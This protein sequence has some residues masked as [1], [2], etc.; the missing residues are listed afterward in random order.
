MTQK[1]KLAAIARTTFS[2][3]VAEAQFDF[4]IRVAEGY[5]ALAKK[6]YPETEKI[7]IEILGLLGQNFASKGLQQQEL[8]DAFLKEVKVKDSPFRN[9]AFEMF[10]N[11][12]LTLDKSALNPTREGERL[13]EFFKGEFEYSNKILRELRENKPYVTEKLELIKKLEKQAGQDKRDILQEVEKIKVDTEKK[14][15]QMVDAQVKQAE[16][17]MDIYNKISS[18]KTKADLKKIIESE[19]TQ[20]DLKSIIKDKENAIQFLKDRPWDTHDSA[21][22]QKIADCETLEKLLNQKVLQEMS[23]KDIKQYVQEKMET[24]KL[25]EEIKLEE[26]LS[27]LERKNQQDLDELYRELTRDW[28]PLSKVDS[29]VALKVLQNSVI[30]G[31]KKL[32]EDIEREIYK[33]KS[34]LPSWLPLP[35]IRFLSRVDMVKEM[36]SKVEEKMNLV[37][38]GETYKKLQDTLTQEKEVLISKIKN[39]H[40]ETKKLLKEV[41]GAKDLTQGKYAPIVDLIKSNK[42]LGDMKEIV[43][44]ANYEREKLVASGKSSV[45]MA[46]QSV[47]YKNTKSYI[48]DFANNLKEELSKPGMESAKNL[49]K[50]ENEACVESAKLLAENEKENIELTEQFNKAVQEDLAF[51]VARSRYNA[52]KELLNKKVIDPVVK[53]KDPL[54]QAPADIHTMGF[55]SSIIQSLESVD[56]LIYKKAAVDLLPTLVEQEREEV[57]IKS[58]FLRWLMSPEIH[59]Y[60][61]DTMKDELTYISRNIEQFPDYVPPHKTKTP[62]KPKEPEGF[63]AGVKSSFSKLTAS[64]R[65]DL[66]IMGE[67]KDAIYSA[68]ENMNK[69]SKLTDKYVK[70]HI[71]QAREDISNIT[72]SVMKSTRGNLRKIINEN[73]DQ[74]K[75]ETIKDKLHIDSEVNAWLKNLDDLEV[76]LVQIDEYQKQYQTITNRYKGKEDTAEYRIQIDKLH[77]KKNELH[78]DARDQLIKMS[79]T[80]PKINNPHLISLMTLVH[81]T[82]L[83]VSDLQDGI[84][85]LDGAYR[86]LSVRLVD[87]HV[88]AFDAL[89]GGPPA[90]PE[91][92]TKQEIAKGVLNTALEKFDAQKLQETLL[93]K[94]L[95]QQLG[96]MDQFSEQLDASIIE[97]KKPKNYLTAESAINDIIIKL[98]AS[99]ATQP[100]VISFVTKDNQVLKGVEAAREI[101]STMQKQNPSLK[102]LSEVAVLLKRADIEGVGEKEILQKKLKDFKESAIKARND[103]VDAFNSSASLAVQNQSAS[104][105]LAQTNKALMI[106]KQ[107]KQA[108][109]SLSPIEAEYLKGNIN[110]DFK[111]AKEAFNI[112]I[113]KRVALDTLNNSNKIK[114]ILLKTKELNDERDILKALF[115]E[116]EPTKEELDKFKSGIDFNPEDKPKSTSTL[117]AATASI[118]PKVKPI[119][120][121]TVLRQFEPNHEALEPG[122]NLVTAQDN[123]KSILDKIKASTEGTSP[124]LSYKDDQGKIY[125]KKVAAKK[126]LEGLQANKVTISLSELTN[127]LQCFKKA[128]VSLSDVDGKKVLG[129]TLSDFKGQLDKT[130]KDFVSE[131]NKH[132]QLVKLSTLSD[133]EFKERGELINIIQHKFD[134]YHELEH[135]FTEALKINLKGKS[136]LQEKGDAKQL[137]AIQGILGVGINSQRELFEKAKAEFIQEKM[138]RGPD[139]VEIGKK[140]EEM[141]K[142]AE[143]TYD[144]RAKPSKP[145]K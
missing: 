107:F 23:D 112:N 46:Q 91:K 4:A 65:E 110:K 134:A 101:M 128:D 55:V 116:F 24:F 124:S 111:L 115:L 106:Y 80:A 29:P 28:I 39:K 145:T 63:V 57:D 1:G 26:E 92:D 86:I 141:A 73:P 132:L 84:N 15:K 118:N 139:L 71:R 89:Q 131:C 123:V 67:I 54:Q 44:E 64:L 3:A 50:T 38:S 8:V 143:G 11:V 13:K 127:I 79:A 108:F 133:Q 51:N 30:P 140:A 82:M 12:A 138:V 117:D 74:F 77:K 109:L 75:K 56:S 18:C 43:R 119:V 87:K 113:E 126:I 10:T 37:K 105:K 81:R 16:I 104:E 95:D 40:F 135:D 61:S 97:S 130:Q 48:L 76:T 42:N 27:A 21:I 45:L 31:E 53:K 120:H 17:M 33:E 129:T 102:H 103:F 83:G 34:W 2:K 5:H 7:A 35:V 78:R 41:V 90:A 114:P 20:Q 137:K 142:S 49:L 47:E 25:P 122:K 98:K 62:E 72:F 60:V 58:K 6:G 136:L 99:I 88:S 100:I 36:K 22:R 85:L 121:P 94:Y 52:I 9:Q 68:K 69:D 32:T 19:T 144:K 14:L 93:N 96:F 125:H 66:R 70:E 59:S